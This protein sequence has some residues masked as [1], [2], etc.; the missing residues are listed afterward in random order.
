MHI[1]TL[2]V[3]LAVDDTG[4]DALMEDPATSDLIRAGLRE[5]VKPFDPDALVQADGTRDV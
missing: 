5:V 1:I 4:W 2:N 3:V